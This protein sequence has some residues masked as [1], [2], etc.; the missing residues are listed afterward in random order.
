MA[1]IALSATSRANLLSLQNTTDLANRTQNRLSTGM[2]VSSALDDAV[3]Y[4]A[5][6]SLSDRSADFTERKAEIDQGISTLKVA[7]NA[8]EAADKI[9]KQ[10]KGVAISAKTADNAT[11]ADL[12][13]QFQ[14][15]LN[16]FNSLIGDATYQGTNLL[17]GSSQ[18]LTVSFSEVSTSEL[19][20]VGREL[21]AG[22][23]FTAAGAATADGA[24]IFAALAGATSFTAIATSSLVTA[25]ND[26]TKS[27]DTAVSAVRAATASLGSNITLL[28]TRLDFS[29]NYINTLTEGADKLTLADLNEEGANLVA[30][31]TRQQLALKALSFAGQNEQAVLQLF[32]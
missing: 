28:S 12:S 19:S 1:D 13:A 15:L 23:L 3:A 9:L 22:F 30:L 2:K 5:S 6:K 27:V 25:I 24:A 29:K 31:Q 7:M 8:T 16:Q 10:I 20:V 17:Q 21:R 11:K 14:D 18:N 26:I 4:F 32:Q